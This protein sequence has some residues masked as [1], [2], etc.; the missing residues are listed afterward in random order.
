MREVLSRY[1]SKYVIEGKEVSPA[2]LFEQLGFKTSVLSD[3]VNTLSGGQKRRLQLMLILLDAPNVLILDEPSND[4]DTDMLVAMETVLDTWPGTLIMVSHD[5]YLM[6][7]VTDHQYALI[8]GSLRHVPRGVDEYLELLSE[9]H[10]RREQDAAPQRGVTSHQSDTTAQPLSG[11]RA[12]LSGGEAY[13]ARKQL[14][15]LERKMKTV[16]GNIEKEKQRQLGVDPAD[17]V[18]LGAIQENIQRLKKE[19]EKLEEAWLDLSVLL[20]E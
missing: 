13:Q 6:E 20:D 4:L 8:D 1:K 5:R 9:S 2:Q 18:E 7:R 19:Q 16:E 15:S 12:S 3:T 11:T 14:T 17:Y 10:R